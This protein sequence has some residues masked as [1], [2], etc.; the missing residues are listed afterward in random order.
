MF[1]HRTFNRD[2]PHIFDDFKIAGAITNCFQQPFDDSQYTEGFIETINRNVHK[3][4]LLADFVEQNNL[5]QRRVAFIRLNANSEEVSDFP[6]LT[7][8]DLI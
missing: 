5:N 3:P 2:L 1:R 8:E 4:N 7:Y 6:S